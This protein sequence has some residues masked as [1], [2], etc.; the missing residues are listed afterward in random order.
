MRYDARTV[1]AAA[2]AWAEQQPEHEPDFRTMAQ[3]RHAI[4]LRVYVRDDDS[5]CFRLNGG[6]KLYWAPVAAEGFRNTDRTLANEA[7]RLGHVILSIRVTR[8]ERLWPTWQ[9]FAEETGLATL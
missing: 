4:I 7:D 6:D 1:F 9:A 2:L 3:R 5:G 8:Q